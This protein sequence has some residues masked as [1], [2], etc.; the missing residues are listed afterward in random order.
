MDVMTPPRDGPFRLPSLRAHTFRSS[1]FFK[2]DARLGLR[3]R[4]TP[5][6]AAKR[7]TCHRSR[8]QSA[9]EDLR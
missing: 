5:R 8:W 6:T 9:R 3:I 4:S 7:L 2:R 1:P